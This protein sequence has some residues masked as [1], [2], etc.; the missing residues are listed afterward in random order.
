MRGFKI[1]PP[2][3]RYM[4]LTEIHTRFGTQG[5]VAYSCKM[6]GDEPEGGHVVAVQEGGNL[7]DI[8]EYLRQF[9]LKFP[10]RAPVCYIRVPIA[11]EGKP[12]GFIYD[13]GTGEKKGVPRIEPRKPSQ[14]ERLI[15][16]IPED[17][18]ALMIG[19][20]FRSDDP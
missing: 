17:V 7:R 1:V 16:H 11:A 19:A 8:K 14:A 6:N 18:L 9:K 5:V 20:A 4:S 10:N 2:P 13:H 15:N 12:L 3:Q